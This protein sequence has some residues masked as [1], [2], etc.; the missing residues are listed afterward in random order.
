MDLLMTILACSL[1]GSDDALVRA[2]AE[3][4]SGK[5]P[6][7]VVDAALDP[8]QVDPPPAPKTEAEALARAQDLLEKGGRPLLGLLELPPSWLAGFGLDLPSAFDPCT[9]VAIGSAM[10]SE[11]D[12][13]CSGRAATSQDR[14]LALEHA[15][16]RACVLRK[17]EAAIGTV[18]FEAAILLELSVQRPMKAQVEATP[19]FAPE[20]ARTWGPDQLLVH[21]PVALVAASPAAV[22]L[23]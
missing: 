19:I 13:E 8:T 16:R 2:I 21:W 6:Y 20:S 7:R 3:G 15:H 5:N 12:F 18:D 14:A 9:N 1:Y 23:P 10:L 17:Y 4:S 22:L 11:F